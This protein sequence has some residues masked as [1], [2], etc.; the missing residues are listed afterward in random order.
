MNRPTVLAVAVADAYAAIGFA[1]IAID[2]PMHGITPTSSAKDFRL[3]GVTERTFDLDFVTQDTNGS[4]TALAPDTVVDSS[5]RHF[6]QLGSLLTT[7][8]NL[9]QAISDLVQLKASL[10]TATGINFDENNVH[11]LGHSLGGM[12]G[13]SFVNIATD[14][15]TASFAMSGTQAAYILTNSASFGPEIAAGLAQKGI[16]AGSADF[17]SFELAAQAVIDSADPISVLADISV[18]TLL[19]EVVGDGNPQSD[20]QVIPNYIA[21][22]GGTE[23]WASVQGLNSV[24]GTGAVTDSKGIIRFTA[25]DHGS[26]LSPA[27]SLETTMG[28]QQTVVSF[29]ATNG[30]AVQI[31]ND[32]TIK[33]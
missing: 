22:L 18:P 23:A 30:T 28:M 17:A 8:D 32:T 33:Q 2:M 9:R 25:G 21:P 11:F 3:N 27:A 6:V 16:E 26:I 20:D 10:A 5:G 19:L 13:A 4:I 29:A 15:K 14:L 1:T 24:T 31:A 7:R 12:V